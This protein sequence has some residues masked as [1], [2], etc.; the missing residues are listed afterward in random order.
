MDWRGNGVRGSSGRE[1]QVFSQWRKHDLLS[2][3]IVLCVD[4]DISAGSVCMH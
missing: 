4:E 2:I 3:S 1:G